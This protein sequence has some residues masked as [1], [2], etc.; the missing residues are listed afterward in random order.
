MKLAERKFRRV[1]SGDWER[2][3][4]HK[5]WKDDWML[6]DAAM[7]SIFD[8]PEDAR[9]IWLSLH[10]RPAINRVK[11][12]IKMW[13]HP[14]SP[15]GKDADYPEICVSSSELPPGRKWDTNSPEIDKVIKPFVGKSLYVQCEY[16]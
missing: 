14:P 4:K 10:T 2:S 1:F 9:T 11:V 5:G 16:Q 3:I 6:C 8:I 12:D 13:K 7:D 15:C